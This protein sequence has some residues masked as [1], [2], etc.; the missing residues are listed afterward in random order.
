M[1][2]VVPAKVL[3]IMASGRPVLYVGKGEGADMVR[4]A[5]SGIVIPPEDPAALVA[6]ARSLLTRPE[7]AAAM[8]ASGRRYVE[9]HLSWSKLVASWLDQLTALAP[10]TA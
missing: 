1:E 2:G 3:A 7:A 10:G 6:A 4:K 9:T 5:R 8:G